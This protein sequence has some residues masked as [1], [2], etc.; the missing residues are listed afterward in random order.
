VGPAGLEPDFGD[1]VGLRILIV[2]DERDSRAVMTTMLSL[3][4]VSVLAVGRVREALAALEEQPFDLLISDLTLVERS[5]YDLMMIVRG[6]DVPIA[7]IPAIAVSGHS[8]PE[9]RERSRRA[10]FQE[11]VAKPMDM[12][13]LFLAIRRATRPK[14]RSVTEP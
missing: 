13:A 2:E 5:G 11:H 12:Q 8:E 10:G 9:A 6:L 1:L 14:S 3:L 4:D 7:A